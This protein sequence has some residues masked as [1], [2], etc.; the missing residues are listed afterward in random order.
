MEPSDP[1]GV[2]KKLV[3]ERSTRK[4]HATEIASMELTNMLRP[5]WKQGNPGGIGKMLHAYQFNKRKRTAATRQTYYILGRPIT[6]G[7]TPLDER[8]EFNVDPFRVSRQSS[9]SSKFNIQ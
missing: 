8:I 2:G 3:Y 1:G 6:Q 4:N 7:F 9:F 5:V